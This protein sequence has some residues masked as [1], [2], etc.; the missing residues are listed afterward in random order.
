MPR[1]QLAGL[2]WAVIAITIMLIGL[3]LFAIPVVPGV[4]AYL[5]CGVI[6]GA[7][8]DQFGDF[9]VTMVVAMAV[10]IFT[11][12][13]ACLMQQ[14][15]F[16]EMLGRCAAC[17]P[18]LRVEGDVSSSS[19]IRLAGTGTRACTRQRAH[20]HTRAHIQ[21][22][23]YCTASLIPTPHAPTPNPPARSSL[24]TDP[25]GCARPSASTNPG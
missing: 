4:P 5:A 17:R 16:G 13:L 11:K 10:A 9:A 20:T 7:A 8:E 14:K 24:L 2:H 6:L 23:K 1:Q 3:V 21:I 12:L 18:L 25:C 15:L 22:N 19:H